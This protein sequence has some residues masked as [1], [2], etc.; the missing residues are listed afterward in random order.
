ML[1]HARRIEELFQRFLEAGFVPREKLHQVHDHR[2]FT[3]IE[4]LADGVQLRLIFR[5]PV[6]AVLD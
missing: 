2:G 6:R 1:A 5:V 4:C 3:L